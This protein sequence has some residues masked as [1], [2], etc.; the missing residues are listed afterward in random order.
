MLSIMVCPPGFLCSQGLARDPQRSAT[1]SFCNLF[2]SQD[3][4]PISC[5]NG[6]YSDFPGLRDVSECVQCPEG[7]YCYSEQPH[8]EPITR[9]TGMCPD[10]HYCPLGTGYPYAFPCK[11]GQYRK[12]ALGHSGEACVL[13]PSSYYCNAM[14]TH[15]PLICP[16]VQ[17]KC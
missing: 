10:G 8:E 13:C 17:W 11:V 7:K 5:P 15:V 14:G 3:P 4:N 6:T 1:L 16:Q 12:T 2:S 9:P